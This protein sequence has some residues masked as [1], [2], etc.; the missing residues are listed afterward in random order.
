MLLYSISV[1]TIL[2]FGECAAYIP[3][4][5]ALRLGLLE[6]LELCDEILIYLPGVRQVRSFMVLR[7]VLS[8]TELPLAL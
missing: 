6:A 3:I 2:N 1:H 7:N 5:T 8:S 4:Q